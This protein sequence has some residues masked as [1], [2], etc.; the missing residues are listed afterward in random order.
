MRSSVVSCVAVGL[1][2]L[3]VCAPGARGRQI[4]PGQIELSASWGVA[5]GIRDLAGLE[6]LTGAPAPAPTTLDGLSDSHPSVGGG[7]A[8]SLLDK[9]LFR[10]DVVRTRLFS[11]EISTPGTGTVDLDTSLLEITGGLDYVL[12]DTEIAP[13]LSAGGGLASVRGHV[14][15]VIND[16]ELSAGA[17]DSGATYHLG[18]GFRGLLGERL[19]FRPTLQF[20]HISGEGSWRATF[21]IFY[22]MN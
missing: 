15:A 8:A 7:V 9:S 4:D 11:A 13:F 18:G 2:A 21:G 17:S 5:G 14:R 10:F 22:V 12:S 16:E 19:G 3:S 1:W 6:V 20:V